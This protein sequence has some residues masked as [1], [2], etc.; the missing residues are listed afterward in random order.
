MDYYDT[1]HFDG[2][3]DQSKILTK[4]FDSHARSMLK[5]CNINEK[6][7]SQQQPLQ[8]NYLIR[9]FRRQYKLITGAGFNPNAITQIYVY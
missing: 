4:G 9:L 8:I 7:E 2:L 6:D 3:C 5:D 1:A